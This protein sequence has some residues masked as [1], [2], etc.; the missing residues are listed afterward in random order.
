MQTTAIKELKRCNPEGRFWIK[1]DGTDIKPALL[2][3]LRQE[4]NGDVNMQDGKLEALRLAYDQRCS[5]GSKW[6]SPKA[7]E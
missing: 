6:K 2:E 3:S 1:A 5:V 4:W 7:I